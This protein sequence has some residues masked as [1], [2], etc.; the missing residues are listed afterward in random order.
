MTGLPRSP[1]CSNASRTWCW[2]AWNAGDYTP[3]RTGFGARKYTYEHICI[4]QTNKQK[5]PSTNN[6]ILMWILDRTLASPI[7]YT[8]PSPHQH[9]LHPF[10]RQAM[11]LRKLSGC[12]VSVVEVC[13]SAGYACYIMFGVWELMGCV[14]SDEDSRAYMYSQAIE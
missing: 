4:K 10:A 12:R 8:L 7:P 5:T 6:V 11:R 3:L 13:T 9:S 2:G 1:R 14:E